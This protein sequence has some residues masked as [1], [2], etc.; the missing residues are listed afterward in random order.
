[1]SEDD[2]ESKKLPAEVGGTEVAEAPE[3]T[4]KVSQPT[5]IAAGV[6]GA[7]APRLL[8]PAVS[9]GLLVGGVIGLVVGLLPYAVARRRRL[10]DDANRALAFCALWGMFGGLVLAVPAALYLTYRVSRAEPGA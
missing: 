7:M 2:A 4:R 5:I 3:E 1:M 8:P 10:P 6:A 9:N